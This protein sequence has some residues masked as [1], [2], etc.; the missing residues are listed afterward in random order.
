LEVVK[1][2]VAWGLWAGS[3]SRGVDDFPLAGR[4]MRWWAVG[5]SVM[6]TQISAITFVGRTSQA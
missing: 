5:L 1:E 2:A 3:G 4:Q 6:T